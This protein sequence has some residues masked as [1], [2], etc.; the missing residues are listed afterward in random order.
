[1]PPAGRPV[2][3]MPQQSCGPSAEHTVTVHR[4]RPLGSRPKACPLLATKLKFPP[5]CGSCPPPGMP[6]L[7]EKPALL[8]PNGMHS[9]HS[10]R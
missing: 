9:E 8:R 2:S 4:V 6:P 10:P 7:Q 5:P 3:V 1:M